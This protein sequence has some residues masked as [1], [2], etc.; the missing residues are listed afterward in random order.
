MQVEA[1]YMK[2]WIAL[3]IL[4]I[5]TS[6]FVAAQDASRVDLFGGFSI[7]NGDSP[8]GNGRD[9]FF[10]WQASATGNIKPWFGIVADFGGQYKNYSNLVVEVPPAA[11]VVSAD[12]RAYEYLFGP[13]FR[14]RARRATVFAHVLVGGVHQY[15]HVGFYAP[16]P[17]TSTG[18]MDG[19]AMGIGGGLDVNL[20]RHFAVRIVQF[21]WMP[22]RIQGNWQTDAV[23][24][25]IGVVAKLGH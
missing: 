7:L 13:Q 23:R 24:I 10:G 5:A 12:V 4:A 22:G 8:A 25:G 9:S 14:L 21:D 3:V 15:A 2:R 6:P 11:Y 19:L 1:G 20:A 17:T 18:T 16:G